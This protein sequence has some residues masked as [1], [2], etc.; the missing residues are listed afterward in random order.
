MQPKKIAQLIKDAALDK[1]AEDPIILD[2]A[3]HTNVAHYF[4]ITHGNS[5]RQVRA[6]AHHIADTLEEKGLKVWHREG[7]E[8]GRW[9]LLDFG[10][11]L[12]HVFYKETRGFYSLE[13]LWGDAVRV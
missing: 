13:R 10:S 12:A 6:I 1:K 4:V 5:D 3:K 11:V 2:V 8:D 7:M 9:V